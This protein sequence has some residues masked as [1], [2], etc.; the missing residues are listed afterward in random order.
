MKNWTCVYTTD[1]LYQAEAARDF[2]I[3]ENID[4]VVMNKKDSAYTVFGEIELYVQTE[5][6]SLAVELIKSFR[7][8]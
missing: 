4:A 3:K 2:L 1:Q 8:E 7:I 6:E 5:N